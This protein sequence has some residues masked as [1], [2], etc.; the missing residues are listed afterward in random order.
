MRDPVAIS[1]EGQKEA[2]LF[3]KEKRP[4]TGTGED[5]EKEIRLFE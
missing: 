4:V 3:K 1:I 2:L 5:R